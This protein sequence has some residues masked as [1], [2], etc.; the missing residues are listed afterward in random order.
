MSKLGVVEDTLFVPMLWKRYVIFIQHSPISSKN[1]IAFHL[2]CHTSA[3]YHF[4]IFFIVSGT[5][6]LYRSLCFPPIHFFG[7]SAVRV[8]YIAK[9]L[10]VAI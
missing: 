3:R 6:V 10:C 4:K 1:M 7:S 8:C 2:C 9:H 5:I